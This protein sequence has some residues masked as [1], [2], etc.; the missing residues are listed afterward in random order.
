MMDFNLGQTLLVKPDVPFARIANMLQA[1]GW[2][3]ASEAQNPLQSGEPE[4]ASWTWGGQK[5]V[6]IYSFNPV[7]KLRVLDVATLPP[8]MRGTLAE[9][10]PLLQEHDVDD[11]LFDPEPRQRLLGLWAALE[12][13]RL[14]LIPQAHRL[15][16]DRDHS[17]AQQSRKLDER[18]Q[19]TLESR[20]ALLINLRLL[21]EVAEDVIRQLDNPL[22]TRQL[23]PTAAEL[24]KL[25]DPNIADALIPQVEQLYQHAPTI[26]PGEDFS[27]LAITAANAGLLRWPNELS[28]KFPRGYRNIAGWMQPQW[29]WLSWRCHDQPG[30]TLPKGGVQYDG[31]VWAETRWVWLPKAFR[32]VATALEQQARGNTVH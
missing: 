17:V 4:Y 13:E 9:N 16:H 21:A 22:Y 10:L 19:K 27:E 3:S 28:E 15:S 1:L 18:F 24:R 8:A 2:Q 26:N 20:E 31:L 30:E 25:F 5:P 7:A 29:I 12:T 23:K 32:L 11:L 6:L 14:D